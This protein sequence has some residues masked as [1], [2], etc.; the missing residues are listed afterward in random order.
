MQRKYIF[1]IL[2]LF[3]SFIF[4][5]NEKPKISDVDI[6][7]IDSY[8]T[9]EEPYKAKIT[10]F[11]SD[12]ATSLLKFEN[13]LRF[14]VSN[15]P[16]DEHKFVISLDS[17]DADST[18]LSY[19]VVI[20]DRSGKTKVSEIYD[21]YLPEEFELKMKDQSGFMNVCLGGILFLMPFPVYVNSSGSGY[22][23]LTKEFP[24][25]SFYG[26]GYNYPAGYISLEYSYIFNA[27]NRNYLR[28]GYKQIFQTGFIKYISPGVNVTTNFKGF[29]GISPEVSF[30]LFDFYDAFTFY[31]RYRYNFEPGSDFED[32]H[33]ISI[34]LFTSSFSFNL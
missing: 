24:V 3:S 2:F 32:F 23:S 9:P 8:V 30:G 4:A 16:A 11:T 17:L 20:S 26:H 13:G 12:S 1:I 19:R 25:I 31:V 5:Q 27:E 34:G 10:F 29:N 22:F 14:D 7:I 18:V 6:F 15:K 28:L 21:L 33:E